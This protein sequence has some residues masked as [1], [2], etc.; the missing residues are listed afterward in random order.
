MRAL[1]RL[2]YAPEGYEDV[3]LVSLK[4]ARE[5]LRVHATRLLALLK[6]D[7]ARRILWEMLSDPSFYV[8][9]AAAEALGTLDP[10]TLREAAQV[11]PDPYG[12]AMAAQVLRE[13][14]WKS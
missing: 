2:G 12:R 6:N 13:A 14:S 8:R 1:W 11:Y 9:R 10:E 7:L 3:L 4:D 5:F